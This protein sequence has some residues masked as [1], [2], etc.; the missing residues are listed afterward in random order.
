GNTQIRLT[1]TNDLGQATNQ[2]TTTNPSGFYIFSGLRPGTYSLQETQPAGY[3]DGKD[4]IGTPGGITSNDL[5]SQIFLQSG[6]TV[7]NNNLGGI[8]RKDV[9]IVKTRP[10]TPVR[11][12]GQIPYSL[13]VTNSG[14]LGA[15]P[16]TVAHNLPAG[17]TFIS[18][19]APGWTFVQSFGVVTFNRP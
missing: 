14:P 16:V 17:T 10:P 4:T 9:G 3:L 7:V 12:R 6:V 13:V 2:T 8:G 11:I 1:G 19:T 18:A 5:F 15:Q